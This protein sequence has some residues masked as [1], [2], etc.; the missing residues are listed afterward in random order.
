MTLLRK[1]KFNL[2]KSKNVAPKSIYKQRGCLAQEFQHGLR[3]EKFP[4]YLRILSMV[5]SQP[6]QLTRMIEEL[7]L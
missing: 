3:G 2:T 1:L 5:Y 7:L 6:S 4:L